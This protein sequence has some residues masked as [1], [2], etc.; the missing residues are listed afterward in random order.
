MNPEVSKV[1]ANLF[2]ESIGKVSIQLGIGSGDSYIK[3]ITVIAAEG[4]KITRASLMRIKLAELLEQA[5]PTKKEPKQPDFCLEE[6]AKVYLEA[7]KAGAHPR[8]AVMT[9]FGVTIHVAN[10]RI[11][12]ARES[13]L[14][15]E[16][17]K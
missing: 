11:S 12:K 3:G 9:A 15:P 13:N 8:K 2:P 6:V 5:A 4:E 16:A 7:A 17:S 10:R 14:I 1:S